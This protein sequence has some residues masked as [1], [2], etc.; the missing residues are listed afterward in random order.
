M[1]YRSQTI[2]RCFFIGRIARCSPPRS[3]RKPS[4]AAPAIGSIGHLI[5]LARKLARK[6]LALAI[7][8]SEL[9]DH[10]IVG[11]D[12]ERRWIADFRRACFR[13]LRSDYNPSID[14]ARI[15]VCISVDPPKIVYA[16]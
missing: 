7:V 12:R 13:H 10:Q 11:I 16:R 2:S 8:E 14:F 4:P 6:N 15:V 5:D 9:C 1:P 3:V